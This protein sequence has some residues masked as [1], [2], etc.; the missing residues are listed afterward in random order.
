M[1][2]DESDAHDARAHR[3]TRWLALLCVVLV[4]HGSL[5]PWR[6]EWPHSL[7]DAWHHMMNQRSWWTGMGDVAGNV[8]LFL[9]V[10][11]LGWALMRPS[12]LPMW[13]IAALVVGVGVAFAF[14]LQVA[15]LF[16]PSR[17]AAWSDVVWNAAGLLLG[18]LLAA[19][20][21]R[22]PTARLRA[23]DL[24]LPLTFVVLWLLLQWWP[25]VPRL[26]WQH[27]KD[28]FKPLLLHPQW[29]T[30]TAID[31]ALSLA[32]VGTLLRPLRHRAVLLVALPLA[33]AVG[34]LMVEH[35][36]L[37]LSRNVGW[38]C[39]LLLSWQA[40]RLPQRTSAALGALAALLWFTV[41]ELRPFQFGESLGEFHWMPFAALLQGS[42]SA[43]TLALTWQ[44]FWL[45]SALMLLHGLGVRA[46]ALAVLLG[47][48][49]LLLELMQTLLPGRVA[50][51]TPA[52]LPWLW[53]LALPLLQLSRPGAVT[54]STPEVQINPPSHAP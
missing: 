6:F 26:D 4:T 33:A 22:L 30:N 5:Y 16:V 17:D 2:V 28:A 44:L 10:G 48:W 25:F 19:P 7:P 51:V 1:A 41:D 23:R 21:L 20:L 8:V 42:L 13:L 9:P 38:L 31:A 46:N 18:L 45:G 50:D 52:L 43:N 34:T 15:Q 54:K 12:R 47:A 3:A 14:A 49:A 39:G 53:C 32:L 36:Y 40:W 24:R 37:S 29:R 35:Q 11:V 27:V